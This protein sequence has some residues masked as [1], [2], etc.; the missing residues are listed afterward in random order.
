MKDAH[1][2]REQNMEKHREKVVWVRS[3]FLRL[4][5]AFPSSSWTKQIPVPQRPVERFINTHAVYGA[6]L[7]SGFSPGWL[8]LGS[9]G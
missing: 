5:Q 7:N 4:T 3:G 1:Q 8:C 6:G 2:I 9:I